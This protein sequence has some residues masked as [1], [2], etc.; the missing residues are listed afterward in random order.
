LPGKSGAIRSCRV[1]VNVRLLT[2]ATS[3]DRESEPQPIGNPLKGRR[4]L[5]HEKNLSPEAAG[6]LKQGFMSA[7]GGTN[8][9]KVAVLE[10]GLKYRQLEVISL[11]DSEILA[12]RK[13]YE[14][15]IAKA[16]GVPNVLVGIAA[17]ASYNN[18]ASL[19]TAWA[20]LNL[21]PLV[22]KIERKFSRTVFSSSERGDVFLDLDISVMQRADPEVR[23]QSHK[24]ALETQVMTHDEVR[25]IEGL[26]ALGESEV[27]CSD[28]RHSSS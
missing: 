23:E 19:T 4:C 14:S 13:L 10:D 8:A 20:T 16:F 1:S 12:S 7:F 15:Q 24:A 5:E 26:S 27:I 18:V 3:D 21:A 22:A 28:P 11:V 17:N 9:R 25:A 2:I 6:R